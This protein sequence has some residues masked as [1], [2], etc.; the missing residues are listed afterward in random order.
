MGVGRPGKILLPARQNQAGN[1]HGRDPHGLGI[2]MS[3]NRGRG[4]SDKIIDPIA[5]H[6]FHRV[7]RGDVG[8]HVLLIRAG[9]TIHIVEGKSRG[10]L[11]STRA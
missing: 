2:G 8:L 7:E 6:N 5:R 3:K 10:P 1:A 4:I 11:E 9:G